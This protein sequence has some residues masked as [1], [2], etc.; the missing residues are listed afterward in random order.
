MQDLTDLAAANHVIGLVRIYGQT[1][2]GRLQGDANVCL[3]PGCA[4]VPAHEQCAPVSVEI[5]A[6][7]KIESIAVAWSVGEYPAV[8]ADRA[9]R[10]C[11]EVTPVQAAIDAAERAKT[12]GY[13]QLAGVFRAD[14][15]RMNVDGA[16]IDIQA[17]NEVVPAF[18]PIHAAKQTTNLNAGIDLIRMSGIDCDRN[19]A[20]WN[21][22]DGPTPPERSR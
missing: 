8:R 4:I 14:H 10:R 11:F 21:A 2:D 7:G 9:K 17:V 18:T 3:F 19:D 5:V 22:V 16:L 20:F 6:G 12:G 15:Y 1:E 13:G